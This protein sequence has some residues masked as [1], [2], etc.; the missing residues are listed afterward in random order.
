MKGG[1]RMRDVFRRLKTEITSGSD[2]VLVTILSATG[3]T[4]RGSGA[5]MLVTSEGRVCGTVGGGAV[6]YESIQR[7]LKC[8]SV[9][10]SARECF[11]L[12]SDTAADIG[13]VCGG[14]VDMYF[15]HIAAGDSYYISL[16]EAVDELFMLGS[17]SRL[18]IRISPDYSS[19]ISVLTQSLSNKTIG[20]P[21]P[22]EVISQPLMPPCRIETAGA[23]YYILRLIQAGRVFIFGGGHVSQKLVPL[24]AGC[25][26]R[27]VVLEDR[28]EF[29]DP[30]LFE[31]RASEIR[32]I[33]MDRVSELVPEITRD[34]LI[35]IMTR[36]HKND[37]LVQY[38]MLK[39]PAYYIGVIGSRHKVAAVNARLLADGYT[40]EDL[41]RIT[42]PIGIDI[43]AETPAQIAVSVTAQLIRVRAEHNG[44]R[45]LQDIRKTDN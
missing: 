6:E 11:T 27:T 33:D 20:A 40:E 9:R 12:S 19:D 18:V 35:C 8:L 45:K 44:S 1:S 30:L 22:D 26:F 25:D 29:T 14:S 43:A 24:L 37:Y 7:A 16:A 10:K 15:K 4:P 38:E 3:S 13:M 5:M 31:N 17:E 2:A 32:L 28:P 41:R 39:T 42:S 36:G 21:V 34:D 23:E